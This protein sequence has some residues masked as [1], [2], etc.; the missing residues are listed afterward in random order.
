MPVRFQVDAFNYNEWGIAK[1]KVLSID[2]DFTLVEN[3]P[4]FKV[5]CSFAGTELHTRT[6]VKG[7]LKKGMTF[8]ARFILTKR[9]LFQ[10]LYDKADDWINPARSAI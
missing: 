10:L 5:K 8:Q 7:R 3:Q 6:G 4:V 2:N 1:G 9:S